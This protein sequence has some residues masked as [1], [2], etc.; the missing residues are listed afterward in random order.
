MAEE[1]FFQNF[2]KNFFPNHMV[3]FLISYDQMID[4][5]FSDKSQ[6]LSSI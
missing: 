3:K 1:H 4:L 5:E 2:F 6:L